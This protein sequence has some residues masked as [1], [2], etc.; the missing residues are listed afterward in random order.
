MHQCLLII[1][2]EYYIEDKL[3]GTKQLLHASGS[4]VEIPHTNI[5]KLGNELHFCS[6]LHI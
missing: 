5:S 1:L 2:I 4:T 3:D 6:P